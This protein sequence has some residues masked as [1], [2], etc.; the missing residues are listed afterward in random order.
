MPCA[1]SFEQVVD[2][3]LDAFMAK[4]SPGD[5]ITGVC[6]P[7]ASTVISTMLGV[8]HEDHEFF[9]SRSAQLL[10]RD[11]DPAEQRQAQLDL[12]A[13]I[14]DLVASK[15]DAPD[16]KIISRLYKKVDS[17]EMRLTQLQNFAYVML[18][19]GHETT[20]NMLGLSVLSFLEHPDRREAMMADPD[21]M[22]AIV[23]EMLRYHSIL[24]DI[25]SRFA[26]ADA[27]IA[28]REVQAGQAV[29]ISGV[30]SNHDP[31]A[32]PAPGTIDFHRDGPD[33]VAFGYGPHQCLG[34]NLARAELAI[35]YRRIF[36]RMPDLRTTKPVAELDF[37]SN[38][39]S[40]GLY[41]L[42]VA[43]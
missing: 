8:P 12:A 11:A 38:G 2:D 39:V 10:M 20:S 43:W 33:N 27:V 24:D 14:A 31:E 18:L 30:A 16:D 42:E 6:L 4:G 40:Y 21:L 17:G 5:L 13:Y 19:A 22:P 26:I 36:E 32:F 15:A 9:Q 3:V 41:E 7:I 34:Q 23:Q 29:C 25:T 28:G 1:P 35:A 37:K